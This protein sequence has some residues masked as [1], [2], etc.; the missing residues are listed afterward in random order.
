MGGLLEGV[1][2]MLFLP[3]EDG[4]GLTEYALLLMLIALVVILILY[5]MGPAIGNLYS[6]ILT[7]VENVTG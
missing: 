7:Q 6:N 4:Q 3:D 1:I 5:V 2:L